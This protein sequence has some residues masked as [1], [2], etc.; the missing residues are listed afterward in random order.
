MVGLP[1]P[2]GGPGPSPAGDLVHKSSLGLCPH[3]W[4]WREK[5]RG[6][7]SN[8][9]S[10]LLLI[11][12]TDM[13]RAP[14]GYGSMGMSKTES[15]PPRIR[16]RREQAQSPVT[17]AT[18]GPWARPSPHPLNVRHLCPDPAW[19]WHHCLLPRSLH[20]TPHPLLPLLCCPHGQPWA[21]Y[22]LK[23]CH[24]YHSLSSTDCELLRGSARYLLGS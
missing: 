13:S 14:A 6:S 2:S 11:Y 9:G 18:G 5:G 20:L 19:T 7:S 15:L 21:F 23:M 10:F 4:G 22:F 3:L 8:H 17:A 24:L 1:E 16:V 12:L